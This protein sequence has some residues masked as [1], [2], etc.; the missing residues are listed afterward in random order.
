V[1][2]LQINDAAAELALDGFILRR[3]L[4]RAAGL[5]VAWVP[6]LFGLGLCVGGLAAALVARYRIAQRDPTARLTASDP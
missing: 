2:A 4:L 6:G 5:S 1:V 3:P